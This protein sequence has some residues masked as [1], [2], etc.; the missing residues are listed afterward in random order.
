MRSQKARET[1]WTGMLFALAIALSYL[2]S[3]V[4]PLLGLMPAIKLGLS[5]IVVMY[6]LLFLR[7]H[8]ALLLV[9]LKALF[10]FLTFEICRIYK[11]YDYKNYI[12][13]VIGPL[14]P[15]MD[16][17]TVL[18]AIVLIAVM[19]A[20]TGS[21]FEQVGLPNI[22]GSVV[23]VFLCGLLNFKGSKVIEKFESV[24]TVLLYGGYILFTIIVLVKKGGNIPQVFA[25]MDTSAVGG[26]VTLPLCIWT[27]ILYVAYN[28]NAIPMGMFSLT[29]QTKRKETLV[30]GIIAGLLMVIPWFL[31]YFAMMCFYGDTSIVGADVATPW[32]EM[33]K[34]VNGG[35]VLL[36][37]FSLVMGW[38]LVETATG[39]IHM[40]IDRFDVALAE[41]GNAK[42]SDR[43]RGLITVATLIAAL[44]LSRIGVVTLIEKGYSY[45]SYG[46]ILF[47]LLPT[48]IIGGYKILRHK[49]KKQ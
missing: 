26:S 25:A 37:L 10:A 36:G 42:M 35:P 18:I 46:F 4:S 32:M 2:E 3:L 23:I 29:R 40:I 20:A 31:S 33:I 41:R 30:S 24:G 9:V 6:A 21:I 48:L 28:I 19:A 43:K 11:V 1:A 13:Q 7:T 8:T 22:L 34:A 17:L 49:E 47:Y 12:R 45:L 38:T 16:I 39:C 5:N 44:L 14:W 15:V 27:G